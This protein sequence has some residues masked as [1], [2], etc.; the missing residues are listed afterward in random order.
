MNVPANDRPDR[1]WQSA[2]VAQTFLEGVR[3]AIPLAQEQID[4]LLRVVDLTQIR[5][6][7][8]LDL[9]CGDGIL[10]RSLHRQ[11][12]EAEGIF[13]D[14]SET[15]LANAIQKFPPGSG[16]R[17]VPGD[18]GE[19]QWSGDLGGSF[20]VIVSGFAI[21]HLPDPR[22]RRLYQEIFE[23]LAP[24]GVFLNLEHVASRS[25]LGEQAFDQLFVDCLHHYHNQQGNAEN[26]ETIAQKYYNRA[27]H[28]ANI[29]ALTEL[30]CQWLRDS[31]FEDVDCFFKVFEIALFGGRKPIHEGE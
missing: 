20:D 12:P 18:L 26:R 24:G 22:K 8:F 2:Q 6:T 5:V 21:H 7:R 30:Q 14:F 4:I 9:G 13:L 10:G 27:D 17:V 19:S 31:G 1:I 28:S 15:M 16:L 11:Y 3:G 25:P 23:Q 29:L